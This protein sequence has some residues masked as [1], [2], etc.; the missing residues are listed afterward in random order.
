MLKFLLIF[1]IVIY[2]L[3]YVGKWF[4]ANW[5][6]KM[7]NQQMHQNEYNNKKEGEVTIDVKSTKGEKKFKDD[8]DYIDYEEVGD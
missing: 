2:V 4:F 8:G 5:I 1:F 3:G 6:K 7:S